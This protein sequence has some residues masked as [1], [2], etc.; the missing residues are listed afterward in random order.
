VNKLIEAF[1][2]FAPKY[3]AKFG[4]DMP[5]SHR[6]A[7]LN[8]KECRTE[9]YGLLE[10][11]CPSCGLVETKR[12]ACRNRACP[13]C[14]NSRTEEWIETAKK[15][16]PNVPYFHLVFTVPSELHF[17][18]R[19]NQSIFYDKLMKAVGETLTAFGASPQWVQGQIGFMSVLHTWDS[20]L[21]YFPHVHVL[22]LGGF[23]D[24]AGKFVPIQR[25][26]VFPTHCLSKR[27][28]TVLL[29]S[30]RDEL[31]ENIPSKFWKLAWV[32]YNK[33]TFPGTQDVIAYLGRYIKRI[34]IGASRIEKVDKHG[35]RF[36]YR[37]LMAQGKSE[38]RP[39]TLSGEEFMRR[40]LQ[41]I[42]PKGFVRLRYFGLLHTRYAPELEQIKRGNGEEIT[43]EVESTPN[44]CTVCAVPKVVVKEIRPWWE[45]RKKK[46]WKFYIFKGAMKPAAQNWV[47]TGSVNSS[48]SLRAPPSNNLFERSADGRHESRLRDPRAGS[49]RPLTYG[50]GPRSVL[51]AQQSVTRTE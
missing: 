51:A 27:F 11:A 43:E 32:V 13:K 48:R 17:I 20:K 14:N 49:P 42:L 36:R 45:G 1:T 29:K 50:A 46:G 6:K 26:T 39:M 22:M 34:G 19:K 8:F 2:R 47:H 24:P 28:K 38:F 9:K 31:G 16:L 10:E 3:L 21:N 23:R 25:E 5:R 4:A 15:R 18:A 30:L 12:G 41:H 37:H 35:V 33:K 40:Y 7:L 44:D